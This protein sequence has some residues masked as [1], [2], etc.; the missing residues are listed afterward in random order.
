MQA[1]RRQYGPSIVEVTPNLSTADGGGTGTI[2][3]Y[4]FGSAA[5]NGTAPGL[6]LSVG[7]HAAAITQYLSEP[8]SQVP[9][10]PFP[11][12]AIDYTIPAGSSG[13]GADVTVS[14]SAGSVTASNSIQYLAAVQQFPFAGA[15]LVQGIFDPKRDVYYFTDATNVRVFSK[16]K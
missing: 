8:Y 16:T 12:E 5:F 7:G 1:K 15:V 4:G 6:Q 13:S 2:Y 10:Y 9:W 14:N 3:G 11:L